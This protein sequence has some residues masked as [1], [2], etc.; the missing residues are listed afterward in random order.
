MGM[1]LAGDAAEKAGQ[2]IDSGEEEVAKET[3]YLVHTVRRPGVSDGGE[4]FAAEMRSACK[5]ENIIARKVT[6]PVQ[7]EHAWL[8]ISNL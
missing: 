2:A 1:T 8:Y 3:W 7:T 6:Y 4:Y 5:A